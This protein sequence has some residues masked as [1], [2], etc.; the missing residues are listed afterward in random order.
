[1]MSIEIYVKESSC[2]SG[3][4]NFLIEGGIVSRL[5]RV[6]IRTNSPN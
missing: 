2:R 6:N 1:M 4:N 3:T 5:V